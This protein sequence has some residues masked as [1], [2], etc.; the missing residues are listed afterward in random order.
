MTTD[1]QSL[2]E[3]FG[4]SS[5]K[6]QKYVYC[7]NVVSQYEYAEIIYLTMQIHRDNA[8]ALYKYTEI[9]STM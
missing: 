8:L 1:F 5:E 6:K 4:P 7:S 2:S 3:A 9:I